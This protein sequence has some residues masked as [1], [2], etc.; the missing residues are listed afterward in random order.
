G[1]YIR[2]GGNPDGL[3][4]KDFFLGERNILE[5]YRSEVVQNEPAF[6]TTGSQDRKAAG[7]PQIGPVPEAITDCVVIEGGASG[8]AD[9]EAAELGLSSM[10]SRDGDLSS[11]A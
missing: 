4:G 1:R 7:T 8:C 10:A 11:V 3:E 5:Y 2:P 6:V 9:L